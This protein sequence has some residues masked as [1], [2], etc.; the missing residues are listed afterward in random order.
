M[1]NLPTPWLSV[2]SLRDG[3]FQEEKLSAHNV[4]WTDVE[5]IEGQ[6]QGSILT[7]AEGIDTLQCR[8]S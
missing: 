8:N 1:Y 6:Q 7:V 4:C 3:S 5:S 2:E